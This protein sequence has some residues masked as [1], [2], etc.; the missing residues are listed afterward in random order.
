M[1][2]KLWTFAD[3]KQDHLLSWLLLGSE[4]KGKVEE[5]Q[6]YFRQDEPRA[7]PALDLPM[8]TQ[9]YRYFDYTELVTKENKLQVLPEQD[10]ILS[11][12]VL[13]SQQ[14]PVASKVFLIHGKI[15]GSVAIIA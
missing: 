8:L 12:R 14:K 13:N 7:A 5:P 3:D 11:G 6:F 1:D 4:L 2:D 15:N 9:G 10:Y